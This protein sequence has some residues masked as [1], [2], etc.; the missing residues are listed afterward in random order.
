MMKVRNSILFAGSVAVLTISCFWYY[1]SPDYEPLIGIIA[2]F[3]GIV[4]SY[5]PFKVKSPRLAV[6]QKIAA[7]DKWR[8]VF[9]KFFW[10]NAQRDFQG[11][12]IIHDV[13]RMD[14]YPQLDDGKGISSWFRVGLI[15]TYHRGVLVG[16]RWTNIIK[17]S[18]GTWK[19]TPTETVGEKVA[20][21]GA[22]PY[23]LI[24]S[25]NWDGDDYYNKPHIFCHFDYKGEPYEEVFYATEGRLE[26]PSIKH[27]PFYTKVAPYKPKFPWWRR[28]PFRRG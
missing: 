27:P 20:L 10:D 12:A 25:V 2:S 28:L 11:D 3:C 1:A 21:V 23:E 26:H 13:G 19:E 15:G 5:W 8:P 24:E 22:I 17:Q 16:F 6:E 18:N 9:E 4:G 14:I 7:R